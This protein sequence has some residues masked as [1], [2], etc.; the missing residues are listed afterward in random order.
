MTPPRSAARRTVLE[1]LDAAIALS[2][3]ERMILES[4]QTL[5]REEIA[6]R[7]EHY[8]RTAEFPSANVEAIN[9]LGAA[10]HGALVKISGFRVRRHH[11][12]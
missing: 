9:K 10:N 2:D 5:A 11:D 12:D 8:D 1:R 3:E 6:P 4:V 7:A